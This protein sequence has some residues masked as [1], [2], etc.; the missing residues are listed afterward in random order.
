MRKK[1]ILLTGSES[2]VAEF[3]IK[4]LEKNYNIIG[5]DNLKKQ[6]YTKYKIDLKTNS[7]FKIKNKIDYII[8]LAAI[9]RD[10]D[11]SRDPLECFNVNVIGTLNLIK[12]ANHKK[13]KNFIFASTQWVYNFNDS[14]KKYENSLIDATKIKSEYAL[15]KYIT[16]LNLKQNYEKYN[17]N[18]TILRFGIIY[19]PR[20]NNFSAVESLFLQVAKNKELK[21]GSLQTARNFIHIDDIVSGIIKSIKQRKFNIYNLEGDKLIN[22]KHVIKTSEKLLNKKIKVIEKN[23]KIKSIR[24]V[25][26]N[27]AKTKLRWKPKINLINGLINIKKYH[28][29]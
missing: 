1:T 2:F 11:C 5:I 26:N 16:E 8:H 21:V 9:S 3:L 18:T 28:K 23:K 15:S 27:K 29:L 14:Q 19:G 25:S 17:L 7:I 4:K 6:P 20:N 22:L 12:F 24:N 10:G 13:I